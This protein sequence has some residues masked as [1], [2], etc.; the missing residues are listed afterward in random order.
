MHMSS[1]IQAVHATNAPAETR[2]ATLPAK[3]PQ[4]PAPNAAPQDTVTI[5]A[6]A[7]QALAGNSKPGA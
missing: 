3:P 7:R 6:S 1:P 5:S 4:T 2:A